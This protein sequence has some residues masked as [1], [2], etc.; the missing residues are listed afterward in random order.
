V[1]APQMAADYKRL[2]E[3]ANEG[4]RELGYA[5]TGALWRSWYD[6]P[7]EAFAAKTDALWNQVNPLYGKLECYVRARLNQKYGSAVQPA[8]GPIRADLLGNMWSQHWGNIYDLAQPEEA[9]LGMTSRLLSLP[10]ATM[11]PKSCIPRISGTHLDRF[12]AGTC[13]LLGALD[14]HAAAGP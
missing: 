8:T 11:Q 12:R 4:A 3:L 14:D 9:S 13:K 6:M 7:P 2:V 5:D 10:M 1:S